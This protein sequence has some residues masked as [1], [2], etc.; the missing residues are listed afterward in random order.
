MHPLHLRKGWQA[1]FIAQMLDLVSGG[2]AREVKV[3]GPWLI[4]PRQIIRHI[5]AVKHIPRA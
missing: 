3:F 5:G 4:W 2:A 1:R